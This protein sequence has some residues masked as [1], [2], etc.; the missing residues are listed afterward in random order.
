MIYYLLTS[1]EVG[2]EKVEIEKIT[3][4]HS[5][6]DVFIPEANVI[7]EINGPSHYLNR[8]NENEPFVKVPN[9]C[10]RH[11]LSSQTR[12]VELNISDGQFL[13]NLLD[14]SVT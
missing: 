7:L 14:P 1:P 11:K 10:H 5:T 2:F 4:R 3:S 9:L 12:I 6:C 8:K 13:D